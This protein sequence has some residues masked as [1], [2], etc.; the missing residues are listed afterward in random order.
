MTEQLWGI[1]A[2]VSFLAEIRGERPPPQAYERL[3]EALKN[4]GIFRE[5]VTT[6]D[7][8]WKT[9]SLEA[10]QAQIDAFDAAAHGM[11][12]GWQD[13]KMAGLGQDDYKHFMDIAQM[14]EIFLRL[15][16]SS[17]GRCQLL[18]ISSL[19]RPFPAQ[20]M[21]RQTSECSPQN[22]CLHGFQYPDL[23]YTKTCTSN[24]SGDATGKD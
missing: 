13:Q 15:L 4:L 21:S 12:E 8:K 24:F 1:R 7:S 17:C 14:L 6:L 22:H 9:M 10:Q 2:K 5:D 19:C 20:F 16:K 18:P 23:A 3:N 11:F